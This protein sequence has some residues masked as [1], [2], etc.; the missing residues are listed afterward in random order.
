MGGKSDLA[1]EILIVQNALPSS[2]RLQAVA[3]VSEL[4]GPK[5]SRLWG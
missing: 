4:N 5:K 2:R 3:T 1:V